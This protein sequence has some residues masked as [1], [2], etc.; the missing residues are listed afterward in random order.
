MKMVDY[1]IL[2]IRLRERLDLS[3][4]PVAVIFRENPPAGVPKFAGSE[5]SGCSFWQLAA[6][7]MTFYTVPSDHCNCAVGSYTHNFSLSPERAEELERAF[8]R[9]TSSGYVKMEEIPSIPRLKQAPNAVIYSPLGDTPADPD[10]VIF[11]ARP[12]QA[13]ILQEAA[14]RIGIGLQLSLLGRPTCMSLPAAVTQGMVTSAGCLGNRIYTGLG[15]D[16]LYVIVPGRFLQKLT[17]SVQ[18]I[19]ESNAKLAEYHRERRKSLI[20]QNPK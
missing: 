16:E 5:P 19:A 8:S 1:S 17:D 18:E 4:R 2:E 6:G 14:L 20:S 12:M 3:R 9:I 11:V 13:M 10:L 7:G 15:D